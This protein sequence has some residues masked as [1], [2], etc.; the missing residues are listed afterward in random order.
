MPVVAA[1]N[2]VNPALWFAR[3]DTEFE[4]GQRLDVEAKRLGRSAL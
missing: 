1:G 2:S 3:L 4:M